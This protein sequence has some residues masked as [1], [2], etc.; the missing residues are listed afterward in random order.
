MSFEMEKTTYPVVPAHRGDPQAT[1][2]EAVAVQRR[3]GQKVC[4]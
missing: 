3:L 2:G 4:W 1:A